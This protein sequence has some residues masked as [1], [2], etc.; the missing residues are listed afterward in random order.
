MTEPWDPSL[1]RRRCNNLRAA[2][3]LLATTL[4][5][6]CFANAAAAAPSDGSVK[7]VRRGDPEQMLLLLSELD[8]N[9]TVS[10]GNTTASVEPKGPL[11]WDDDDH[12]LGGAGEKEMLEVEVAAF[13]RKFLLFLE[14]EE[15]EEEDLRSGQLRSSKLIPT[16]A[17]RSLLF[18]LTG[19]AEEKNFPHQT[20]RG[21]AVLVYDKGGCFNYGFAPC[22]YI[23]R[24]HEGGNF[25][26]RC[27]LRALVM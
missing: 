5:S 4:I 8:G 1:R 2:L 21:S 19:E 7:G 25:T 20:G 11:P 18:L 17:N 15:E 16:K 12:H 10:I 6:A 22:I 14:E 3:P 13:G 26:E 23:S 24:C 27:G 9:G